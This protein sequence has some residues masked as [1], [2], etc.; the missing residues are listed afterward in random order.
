MPAARLDFAILLVLPH[1]ASGHPLP[2]ER[3]RPPWLPLCSLTRPPATLSRG[4]G[5]TALS[6]A[7]L[8]H[9]AFGHPLPGGEGPTALSAAVLPHP[10]FGHPLPGGEGTKRLRRV[11]ENRARM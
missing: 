5:P 2:G 6:A 8:P 9:P 4:E 11:G 1:P 10:A 3:D 7:V